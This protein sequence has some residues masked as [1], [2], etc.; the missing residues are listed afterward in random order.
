MLP[1]VFTVT[2]RIRTATGSAS[3]TVTI[4]EMEGGLVINHWMNGALSYAYSA[5]ILSTDD[6][7]GLARKPSERCTVLHMNGLNHGG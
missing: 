1:T 6:E 3:L 7:A 4:S 2:R 5:T